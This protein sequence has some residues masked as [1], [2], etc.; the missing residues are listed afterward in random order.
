M[1]NT[2]Y[3]NKGFE[4]YNIY[5]EETATFYLSN[6]GDGA[7]YDCD[8]IDELIEA[9]NKLGYEVKSPNELMES[10]KCC[11][12]QP[13][14]EKDIDFETKSL[15]GSSSAY[16]WFM[17]QEGDLTNNRSSKNQTTHQRSKEIDYD[18]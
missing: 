12:N 6:G 4:G 15:L 8:D 3:Y 1:K 14:A 5:C 7:T 2:Y 13:L 18:R 16:Y 10:I 9:Y 17:A 11:N